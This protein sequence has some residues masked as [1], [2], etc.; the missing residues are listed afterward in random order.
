[1]AHSILCSNQKSH[2][3]RKYWSYWDISHDEDEMSCHKSGDKICHELDAN[4]NHA[5]QSE[6]TISGNVYD[7]SMVAEHGHRQSPPHRGMA[8][9]ASAMSSHDDTVKNADTMI[10]NVI[11]GIIDRLDAMDARMGVIHTHHSVIQNRLKDRVKIS[12][13]NVKEIM[14]VMRLQSE[15]GED[16]SS[17]AN[18]VSL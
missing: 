2:T 1:M 14:K 15:S 7:F 16:S 13:M 17:G 11:E 3:K 5:D 4:L 9:P 10:M 12:E 8:D 6:M 18:N